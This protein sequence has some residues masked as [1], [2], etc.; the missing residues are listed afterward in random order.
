MVGLFYDANDGNDDTT[1][2]GYYYCT[3]NKN[4]YCDGCSG[5]CFCNEWYI[6]DGSRRP[7]TPSHTLT[8]VVWCVIITI[9]WKTKDGEEE[10]VITSPANANVVIIVL[11]MIVH[12]PSVPYVIFCTH[13]NDDKCLQC[14]EGWSAVD[15]HGDD[16]DGENA[17]LY[18]YFYYLQT[19]LA[20]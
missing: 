19:M 17:S 7:V 20:L 6:G 13:C 15:H 1:S 8:W 3:R 14:E 5:T 4:G 11:L 18:Y 9:I 12:N 16:D 2:N 10:C